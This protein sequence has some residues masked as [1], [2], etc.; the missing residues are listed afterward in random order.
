[1][2]I[3]RAIQNAVEHH[4]A[5][6]LSQA[7]S[8][9]RQIL[10]EQPDQP[11]IVHLLGVV[12]AQSGR[13]NLACE[14]IRRAIALRPKVANYHASLASALA[15]LG[16]MDEAI[17]ARQLAVTLDPTDAGAHLRLGEDLMK[18]RRYDEAI[19]AC[20]AALQFTPQLP[21]ALFHIG[22]AL[23]EKGQFEEAIAAYHQ[24]ILLSPDDFIA[25][26]N[27]AVAL[28]SL[29][30]SGEAIAAC[31]Q[32]LRIS[33]NHPDALNNLGNI[34][35]NAG[36]LDEALIANRKAIL[37]RPSFAAAHVN[38]GNILTAMGR[39]DE[40]ISGFQ[41]ALQLAPDCPEAHCNLGVLLDKK[42]MIDEAISAY[43]QAI[44]LRPGYADAHNNLGNAL[45]EK[46][47]F[48][49][50]L[51]LFRQSIVLKPNSPGTYCNLGVALAAQGMLDEAAAAIS[52]AIALK[53]DYHEAHYNLGNILKEQGLLDAALACYD[54]AI[55][56]Q[57]NDSVSHSNRI[58]LTHFH[59]DFDAAT[60]REEHRKWNEWH[61]SR[62]Y[63]EFI[64]HARPD[65][66]D[67]PLRV[68]YVSPD[69]RSHPVGR[70]IARLLDR[71]DR[72]AFE[73]FCYS[74]VRVPDETTQRLARLA[75][76]WRNIAGITDEDVA[77][78]I[79][80]DEI[81]ILVDLAMHTAHNRLLVFARK[82]APVQ[83]TYLAYCSTTGL[84]AIDYRLTDR[85]L[86]PPELGDPHYCEQTAWLPQS[87]WCFEPPEGVPAVSSLAALESG[88]IT[89]GCLNNFAKVSPAALSVWCKVLRAT[90][91]SRLLIH[92]RQGS[93]RQRVMDLMQGEG[94]DSER[95]HFVS[96]MPASEYFRQYHHIDI[97]LDPFPCAG[98]TTTCD[99]LWMGVPVITLAG[100]TSVGRSG[101]SILSNVGL[102]ELVAH[103]QDQYVRLAAGLAADLPRL[104]ALRAG[105]RARM[106]QSPLMDAPHFARNIE[107]AFRKMWQQWCAR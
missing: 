12:A 35:M 66:P 23:Q 18:K 29:G 64:P 49:E 83:V 47:R 79:R 38:L 56:L 101:V 80:R 71:H 73:V 25:Q 85:Y 54:R 84:T 103:T 21:A 32:A 70:F 46:G 17:A 44:R 41:T 74:N 100:Q 91:Q 86:D 102:P 4:Q 61:A 72:T 51:A 5:G 30:R 22:L 33:E 53:P 27:L 81:D 1:M 67:R 89:F 50:A 98:G 42:G 69:L 107:A 34:L 60:I 39:L 96:R 90:P 105:L 77:N 40:A 16:L 82:P 11:D 52:A 106:Q 13:A 26:L 92:S 43:E 36:R 15:G 75:D 104:A 93:H 28:G 14:L 59:L 9:Y 65:R 37:F 62:L 3:E 8:A 45:V 10:A 95:V 19:R 76:V 87:Y 6:R 24:Y 58:Y 7:E 20:R 88:R 55:A 57:P 63:R 68:G 48:E 31:T 99:A 78:L 97:G 94:V 2:T